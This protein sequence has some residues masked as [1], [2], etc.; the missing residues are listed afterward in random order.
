MGKPWARGIVAKIAV[1]RQHEGKG[2]RA[3]GFESVAGERGP[4]FFD[5][6]LS[7]GAGQ[8]PLRALKVL[9]QLGACG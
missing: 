6:L 3:G 1:F 9:G 7:R 5:Q 4:G 2:A 8:D